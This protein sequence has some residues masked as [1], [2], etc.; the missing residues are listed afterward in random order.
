M[1]TWDHYQSDGGW[2]GS[3]FGCGLHVFSMAVG[4]QEELACFSK[5]LAQPQCIS[6]EDI[7][8]FIGNLGHAVFHAKKKVLLS[9]DAV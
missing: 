8:H 4:R 6:V 1:Y 7:P 2:I 5:V 9:T 3:G